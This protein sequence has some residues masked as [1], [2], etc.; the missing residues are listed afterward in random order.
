MSTS[1]VPVNRVKPQTQVLHAKEGTRAHWQCLRIVIRSRSTG[2]A[3]RRLRGRLTTHGTTGISGMLGVA[4]VP[5]DQ[6]VEHMVQ[7]RQVDLLPFL[8][9]CLYSR[10]AGCVLAAALTARKQERLSPAR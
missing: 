7:C 6:R 10:G 8:Y 2:R 4:G 3:A 1:S 5:Q 9:Q